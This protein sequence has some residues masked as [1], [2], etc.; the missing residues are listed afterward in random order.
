LERKHAVGG[1]ETASGQRAKRK[2]ER[3]KERLTVKKAGNECRPE[4]YVREKGMGNK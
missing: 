4:E 2:C 1:E 3:R